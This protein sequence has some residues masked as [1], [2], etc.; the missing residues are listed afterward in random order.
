MIR[1]SN[2]KLVVD[3]QEPH[4][5][6]GTI[7]LVRA[8]FQLPP[9]SLNPNDR[10]ISW[11]LGAI[12][13]KAMSRFLK[14]V[15]LGDPTIRTY[16]GSLRR[17]YCGIAEP[18]AHTWPVPNPDEIIEELP[19]VAGPIQG[20][21]FLNDGTLLIALRLPNGIEVLASPEEFKLHY[22]MT[23]KKHCVEFA[24]MQAQ[25]L[26]RLVQLTEAKPE[27]FELSYM[28]ANMSIGSKKMTV[29]SRDQITKW[30]D[31]RALKT[32]EISNA[33]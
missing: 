8:V 11:F 10:T 26:K 19:V 33:A 7:D 15:E 20:A 21:V 13:S 23:V 27:T 32:L 24:Q 12:N 30:C 17:D 4:D 6:E 2:G 25:S 14:L 31:S 1:Q 16:F 28:D 22:R 29:R 18:G 3:G 9:A 5:I